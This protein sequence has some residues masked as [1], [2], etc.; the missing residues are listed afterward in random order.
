[1]RDGFV[2]ARDTTGTQD[3]NTHRDTHTHVIS[4]ELRGQVPN[5]NGEDHRAADVDVH[6]LTS[7]CLDSIIAEEIFKVLG[8]AR[9]ARGQ[10][11]S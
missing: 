7:P 8:Y 11:T 5:S 9:D 4:G 2:A 10:F 3:G 1:M 6:G